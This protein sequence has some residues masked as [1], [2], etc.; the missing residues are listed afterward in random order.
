M[1][2]AA[3]LV[4]A[5]VVV[6]GF[7]LPAAAQ[8]SSCDPIDPSACLYPWPNDYFTKPDPSTATGKRLDLSLT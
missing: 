7:A 8:A 2:R 4:T 6:A 5:A 3:R 1:R